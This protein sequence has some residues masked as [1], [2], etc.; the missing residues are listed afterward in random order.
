MNVF[1][2]YIA[3]AGVAGISVKIR[4]G[5]NPDPPHQ[6][7]PR[8]VTEGDIADASDQVGVLS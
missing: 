4:V 7:A 6:P 1:V 5:L 8:D 3:H 2:Q